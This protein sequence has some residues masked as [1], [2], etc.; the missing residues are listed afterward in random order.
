MFE[1]VEAARVWYVLSM[2]RRFER[3]TGENRNR[4]E[5]KRISTCRTVAI[6][7]VVVLVTVLVGGWQSSKSFDPI[8]LVLRYKRHPTVRRVIISFCDHTGMHY[9][10]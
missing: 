8:I 10:N 2:A 5:N 4:T 7:D 3:H 6:D 1:R 9:A